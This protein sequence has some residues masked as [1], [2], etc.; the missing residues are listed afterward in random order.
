MFIPFSISD[1]SKGNVHSMSCKLKSRF[2]SGVTG[3]GTKL[4]FIVT[5][6]IKI[7]VSQI[8]KK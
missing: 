3:L 6:E 8:G 1:R 5:V 4:A 7:V 2:Y